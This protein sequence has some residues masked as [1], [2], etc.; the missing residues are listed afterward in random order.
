MDIQMFRYALDVINDVERSAVSFASVLLPLR[1]GLGLDDFG[2]LMISMP[3]ERFPN[4]SRALPKMASAEVQNNWTGNNGIALLHQSVSFVRSAAFNYV[5]LTGK[6]LNGASILDYGCGYG[7]L[8]RLMYYF[9]DPDRLFGVDPWDQSI[10]ECREAGMGANFRL[11]DYLPKTLPV[12]GPFDFVYAFSVFTHTSPR[13]TVAALRA[14]RQYIADDGIMLITIRPVEYWSVGESAHGLTDASP[15]IEA[16]ETLGFAFMP[17]NLPPID[18]DITYGNTSMT[19]AWIE[20]NIPRWRVAAVDH[21]LQDPY[22]IYVA[23]RP[24]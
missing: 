19:V 10:A 11:S 5:S 4:L 17:H 22:Q 13:A 2:Q 6:T 20:A 3:S 9:T 23:L 16:H 1:R 8:A 21:S 24:A 15:M 18:G 14:C 7:R 12:S